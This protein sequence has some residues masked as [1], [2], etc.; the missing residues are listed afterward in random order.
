LTVSVQ[1]LSITTKV[2]SSLRRGELDTTLCDKVCQWRATGQWF[3]S[4]SPVSSINKTDHCDIT[5]ILLKV[6]LNTIKQTNRQSKWSFTSFNMTVSF[7][8][9][10]LF[11]HPY[12][13]VHTCSWYPNQTHTFIMNMGKP[14][15]FI[16]VFF[17]FF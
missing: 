1:S 6:A 3:S 10:F 8:E 17:F 4:G 11:L 16:L 13:H 7:P 15:F 14:S 12:T 2:V 9:F 5:E